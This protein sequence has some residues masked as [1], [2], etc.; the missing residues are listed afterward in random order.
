MTTV[1]HRRIPGSTGRP[2]TRHGGWS[3]RESL[4]GLLGGLAMIVVM[5]LVMGASG[6]SGTDADSPA[7]RVSS[8]R[9]WD[10]GRGAQIKSRRPEYPPSARRLAAAA[11]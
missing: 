8:R 4:A 1:M 10:G 9:L 11:K 6:P 7:R 5:I 3:A 2:W